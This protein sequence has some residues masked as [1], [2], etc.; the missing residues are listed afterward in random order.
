VGL[1]AFLFFNNI[2]Y[3]KKEKKLLTREIYVPWSGRRLH[4]LDN[5]CCGV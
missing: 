1:G 3:E 2:K 5:A 4:L